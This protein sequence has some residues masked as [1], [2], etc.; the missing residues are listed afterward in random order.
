MAAASNPKT[1][2]ND[3]EEEKNQNDNDSAFISSITVPAAIDRQPVRTF[4]AWKMKGTNL[5]LTGYSRSR[6]KT[7]FFIPELKLALDGGYCRGR[8]AN[9]LFLT[10]GHAD[11]SCDIGYMCTHQ[12]GMRIHCPEECARHISAYCKAF[13]ELNANKRIADEP[14]WHFEIDALKH[15]DA[16]HFGP[17]GKGK[18]RAQN[19]DKY[20]ATAFKCHHAVPCLGFAF[21][22][23]RRRRKPECQPRDLR[24][25]KAQLLALKKAGVELMEPYH[26]PLFVY[27]GDTSIDIFDT[28]PE[29]LKFPI[30][31]IE[32]TFLRDADKSAE[33]LKSDGHINWTQLRP[34]VLKY[35]SIFVLI[36]FSCRYKEHEIIAF[37]EAADERIQSESQGESDLKNC[38]VWACKQDDGARKVNL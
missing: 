13:V 21:E 19:G 27:V 8:L 29:I 38:V 25:H 22:E 1:L 30:I 5:T 36:H 32:C 11:H 10:H 24:S 2:E 17:Q 18:R 31:I 33:K 6:D 23:K 4:R 37:F 14:D 15:G 3:C 9:H 7:F 28:S 16:V 20:R 12:E 35:S 34:F 26:L